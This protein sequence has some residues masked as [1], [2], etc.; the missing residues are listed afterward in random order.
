MKKP[1]WYAPV[2][3]ALGV[4]G[5]MLVSSAA[6]AQVNNYRVAYYANA[7]TRAPDETVRIVNPT[8]I[9]LCANIYVFDA[10]QVMNECCSCLVTHSGLATLSVNT[11]LTATPTV[12]P[13]LTSE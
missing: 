4:A 6:W 13:V 10:R 11:N 12:D 3:I 9:A 5:W 7:H 1:R 8:V 2:V